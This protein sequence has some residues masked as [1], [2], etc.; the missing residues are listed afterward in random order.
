M[1]TREAQLFHHD[2]QCL[3]SIAGIAGEMAKTE[4]PVSFPAYW[5]QSMAAW[6]LPLPER[7]SFH[8]RQAHHFELPHDVDCWPAI[9][10]RVEILVV[11]AA[12]IALVEKASAVSAARVDLAE[13]M[14]FVGQP[15]LN[16]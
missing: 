12:S 11:P 14:E 8:S 7:M 10:L 9:E 3:V 5:S 16:S 1:D 13:Q 4:I 15:I 2:H 6:A